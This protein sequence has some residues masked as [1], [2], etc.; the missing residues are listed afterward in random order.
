MGITVTIL[1]V[2]AVLFQPKHTYNQAPRTI[3]TY[4]PEPDHLDPYKRLS[5]SAKRNIVQWRQQNPHYKIVILTNQTYQ[6]YVT[7]SDKV[8]AHP[9]FQPKEPL[10]RDVLKLWVLAEHGGV[11]LEPT[12]AFSSPLDDW[13]FPKYAEFS[14][15]PLSTDFLACNKGSSYMKAWRDEFSELVRFPN[16]AQYRE[17]RDSQHPA[18]QTIQLAATVVLQTFPTDSIIQ[19]VDTRVQPPHRVP[20][21]FYPFTS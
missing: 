4:W 15:F 13:M 11:W 18:I 5:E 21:H 1:I 6:G 16:E 7:L 9:A 19:L 8:R 10:F 2:C 3:W 12:V 17:S 14:S 20:S